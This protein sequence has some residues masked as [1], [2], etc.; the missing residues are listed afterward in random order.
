MQP[1]SMMAQVLKFI[2]FSKMQKS[3]YL[4][5]ETFFRQIKKFIHYKLRAM[6]WQK[7]SF[8]EEVTFNC[9]NHYKLRAMLWQKPVF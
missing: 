3:E 7:T 9:I 1:V 8:L 6:L 5:N 2:H 4:E